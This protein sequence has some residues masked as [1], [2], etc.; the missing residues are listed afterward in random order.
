V[1]II[2]PDGFMEENPEAVL[3]EDGKSLIVPGEGTWT[4]NTDGTITYRSEAGTQSVN[5]APISYS[6]QDTSGNLIETNT[7]IKITK[8][9]IA[10]VNDTNETCQTADSVPIFT[11]VGLGLMVL[12]STLFGIV[13]FR[14]EKK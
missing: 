13:M 1:K 14:R 4:V 2:L 9:N 11:E 6:V 7:L 10:G 3:S 12:L 5:P 8:S